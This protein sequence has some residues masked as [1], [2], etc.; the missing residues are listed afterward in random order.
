MRKRSGMRAN[1][2]RPNAVKQYDPTATTVHGLLQR[3]YL[4]KIPEN[5]VLAVAVGGT[6]RGRPVAGHGFVEMTGYA[7]TPAPPR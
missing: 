6:K 3:G 4:D 1:P 5:R 2:I 7:P